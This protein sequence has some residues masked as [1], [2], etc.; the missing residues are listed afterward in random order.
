MRHYAQ[1]ISAA[2]EDTRGLPLL[3]RAWRNWTAKRSLAQLQSFDD[4]QLR[5][6]GVA[7][8]DVDWAAGL[9]L[10]VNAALALEERAARYR[11]QRHSCECAA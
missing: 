6:I 2:R 11:R 3:R 9:P 5:D 8:A 1:T 10:T 7:R 4:H